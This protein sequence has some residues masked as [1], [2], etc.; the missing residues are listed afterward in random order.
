MNEIDYIR[1][2]L[3]GERSHLQE[4]LAGLRPAAH[5]PQA[6]SVTQ[7]LDWAGQR[8]A[9]Q[10]ATLQSALAA[11]P[12]PAPAQRAGPAQPEQLLVLL[13][14]WEQTLD[15][16]AARALRTAQWRAVAH[17]SADSILDERRLFAAAR[18]AA[19]AP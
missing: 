5:G 2:Q 4:I 10:L 13:A 18:A 17:L 9:L 6:A 7:Y 8:L 3:A 14:S 11:A 1:Q 16:P 15:A 12:D 19:A